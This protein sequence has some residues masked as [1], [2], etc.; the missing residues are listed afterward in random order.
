MA[1]PN[2]NWTTKIAKRILLKTLE[3]L[4][5]GC[6]E[7]VCPEQTYQFGDPNAPMRGCVVVHDDRAF[8]RA[9]FG[10]DI[11]FGEAYMDADWSSPNVVEVVRLV[12]RNLH[13]FEQEKTWLSAVK[14][15]IDFVNH[16]LRPNTLNGSRKNIRAHYDLS[17][18]FYQ[19]F[20]DPTL[21]YSCGVYAKPDDSLIV[22]Q[23]QKFDLICRKLQLAPEDHLL[24]IG[25]GWG[26]F[27]A[28]AARQYGCKVT[29]TTIS[30][31]QHDF[32]A[33]RFARFGL[34]NGQVNLLFEDYRNL[35]GKFDK[36]VSIEM[37]E[38]VGFD[39]YDD[40]FKTCERLLAENGTMLLQ[41]ITIHDQRFNEYRNR[42]D[43]IQKYI[44]PGGELATIKG[45]LDSL[46]RVTRL[47]LFHAENIG[48]HYART[49]QVWR[50]NFH[51]ALDKV[52]HLEF[53][54]RFIN[55]WDY[56]LASCEAAFL[57]RSI[58]D[59]Q[60]LLAKNTGHESL[61]GEPWTIDD[62]Q[63]SRLELALSLD[64]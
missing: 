9:L 38:A 32:A 11:G 35:Q 63:P 53:D 54:E 36:I 7:V 3:R 41:T 42:A 43:W 47:S 8:K 4:K 5:E 28:Y 60:L 44:F 24:E 50:R 29:T 62:Y 16:K 12:I 64:W 20:L 37:F 40:Y 17:N 45:I 27:A 39:Y 2:S 14:K 21:A 59:Y 10:G 52:R 22:S 31:E 13:L 61:Y 30:K 51:K 46:A 25:T 57:E 18:D 56:Y 26:G 1:H 49:L 55:M 15:K 34:A 33:E 58:G 23:L 48:T 19:L 6:L